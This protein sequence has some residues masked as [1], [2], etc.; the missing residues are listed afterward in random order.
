MLGLITDR[1]QSNV[2]RRNVLSKKGWQNMTETERA[3]WSG[4]PFLSEG[5]ANLIPFSENYS[6]GTSV[7]YRPGKIHVTSNWDGVYIYAI[8]PLGAAENFENKAMT[9]SLD[10]FYSSKGTPNIV[11]YWHD[12]NGYEYA[13]GGLTDAGSMA[14]TLAENTAG[15]ANLAMYLY[16][17]TDT[18][19]T[20]G[21][22]IIYEGLM[23]E[24]GSVRSGYVPYYE[25]LPTAAT[26]GSYNYSD[27]NRVERAVADMAGIL[28]I[29]LTTKTNWTVWDI[30]KH[31]DMVRFLSNIEKLRKVCPLS[32]N[33][34][35][36]PTSMNHLT[37]TAA[38][39][40]E[41]IIGNLAEAVD[42]TFRSGELYSGEV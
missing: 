9:L 7:V 20:A 33:L 38:N 29:P 10:S 39:N 17:T 14:F 11:L 36:T 41:T 35:D 21:D 13:G 6:E 37:Y 12:A 42:S 2:D 5:G 26:K 40:I 8:L 34:P 32:P 24:F 18:E 4:D 1:T 30:P 19:I 31:S 25:V 27:L 28:G 15:R 16:V 22:F 23:L 3:E